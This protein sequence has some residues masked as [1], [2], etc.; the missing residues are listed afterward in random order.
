MKQSVSKSLLVVAFA[1]FIFASCHKIDLPSVK[2]PESS[3]GNT[4]HPWINLQL[5]LIQTTPGFAPPV[6]A[7]AL[8]YANLASYETIVHG[9]PNFQS[10][11]S[12]L[13]GAP[14]FPK[15]SPVISYNWELAASAAF[16][17]ILP[18]LYSNTSQANLRSIDSLFAAIKNS[19][20]GSADA[21]LLKISEEY[22]RSVADKVFEWS[23]YDGGH[24]AQYDNFP[25][26]VPPAGAQYWVP[27]SA[28]T[29]IPLLS[30]WGNNRLF[31]PVNNTV[32]IPAPL[33][34]STTTGSDEYLQ[35]LEVYNTSLNLTADQRTIALFWAD[36]GG[37]ITP[38][39]HSF[40]IARQMAEN[41]ALDLM[42]TVQLYTKVGIAVSDAFVCCWKTK[43]TYNT[44]RPVT[45]I[46][47]Y[48][49]AGWTPLIATPPF[50]EHC[51]GHSTQS[52]AASV[53]LTSVF[54]PVAF[55]DHTHDVDGFSPR[56]FS[57]FDAFAT[58]AMNSRL[59]G[60][61]HIKKGNESGLQM[62]KLIADNVL[63]VKFA[64]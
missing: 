23:Q 20:A 29:P 7:R 63:K 34:F 17:Q 48:I 45:Y 46:R 42:N 19:L 6:A 22:G 13:N 41:K 27:T 32:A 9:S 12:Q 51:S 39:G 24:N 5:R 25:Y 54:G 4:I 59:Y 26:Y 50:P 31:I 57:S 64:K 15:P 61:I 10:I 21:N 28:S 18:R 62:G 30:G 40:S 35:H 49:N 36:G 60:G 37:S 43:Y 11:A 1:V 16:H 55:A 14:N 3:P 2:S 8:A 56:S 33:I 47:N 52:G 44:L 53:I 58:E 38:G